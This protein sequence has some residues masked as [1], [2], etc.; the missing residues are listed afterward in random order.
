M[1]GTN[2]DISDGKDGAG[3]MTSG[4]GLDDLENA[5]ELLNAFDNKHSR[6]REPPRRKAQVKP[7]IAIPDLLLA[8]DDG[9]SQKRRRLT[10]H[11]TV[12]NGVR[13]T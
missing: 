3:N 10:R 2:R 4:M 11:G 8:S 7:R 1:E 13:D 12:G 9:P 6:S 5:M